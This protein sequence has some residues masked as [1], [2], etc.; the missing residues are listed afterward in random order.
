MN[1]IE[2]ITNNFIR[3]IFHALGFNY[4][5]IKNVEHYLE[6]KKELFDNV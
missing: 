5:T 4:L 2:K 3:E 6:E 1:N